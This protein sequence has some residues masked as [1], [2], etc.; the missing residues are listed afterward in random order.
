MMMKDAKCRPRRTAAVILILFMSM[1]TLTAISPTSEADETGAARTVML[2]L[3]TA[4]WCLGC[5][6]ADEAADMLSVDFGPERLSV[7]QYHISRLDPFN[8]TETYI[9]GEAYN[10]GETGLPAAW[11]D[12]TEGVHSVQNPTTDFFYGLF[13]NKI[14]DR[15]NDPSPIEIFLSLTEL[16]GN[17]TVSA[18]FQEVASIALNPT[19][20]RY[21]LYENSVVH[22]SKVYNYVVRDIEE[23]VFDETDLPY[24]EDVWFQLDGG[25]DSSNMG[26]VVFVQVG[27]N[28]D[29]IQS[30]NAVI[31]PKPTVAV[32][33]DIDGEEITSTTRIEGTASGNV[34]TIEIRIDDQLYETAEGRYSWYFDLDPD[35][36]ADGNHDLEVRAYSDSIVYS[37]SVEMTFS[38]I[39]QTD[40]FM[41]YLLIII[42]I[43]VVV[44]VAAVAAK[45]S[46]GKE[47]EE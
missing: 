8:T 27:D 47:R 18:S 28:A 6:Y 1:G 4:T 10:R 44:I 19:V 21:A 41:L 35:Q 31:G 20:T 7:L 14:N 15:L 13:E 5:P 42:I 45:R 40:D 16:S 29:I 23:R 32:T 39:G 2:E 3:I 17:L 25:W 11:I 12:G 43:I 9:R 46:K 34:D 38:S 24:N 22:D 26:V 37:D 30:A 36:L 33:T